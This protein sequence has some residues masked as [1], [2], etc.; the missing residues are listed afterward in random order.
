MYRVLRKPRHCDGPY[1]VG[2]TVTMNMWATPLCSIW[3]ILIYPSFAKQ[4]VPWFEQRW[5]GGRNAACPHNKDW[6]WTGIEARSF[7]SKH[8]IM[9]HIPT[10]NTVSLGRGT[11]GDVS[12]GEEEASDSWEGTEEQ[13]QRGIIGREWFPLTLISSPLQILPDILETVQTFL[14]AELTG[15]NRMWHYK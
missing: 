9:L 15:I 2:D 12:W 7:F 4:G 3:L 13:V 8:G 5:R 10:V 1:D 6:K 11:P 14:E